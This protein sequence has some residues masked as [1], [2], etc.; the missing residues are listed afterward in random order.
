[1]TYNVNYRDGQVV[2][3]SGAAMFLVE[4]GTL[5]WIP[6]MPTYADLAITVTDVSDLELSYIPAGAAVPSVI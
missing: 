5:R 6:D 4:A 3:G 1:M 2:R